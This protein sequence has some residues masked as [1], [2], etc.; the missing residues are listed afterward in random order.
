ML[1]S[2]LLIGG[3]ALA[4][5]P[6]RFLGGPD[7]VF[8]ASARAAGRSGY[9]IVAYRV[10][11]DGVVAD[12]TVVEAEPAGVFEAAALKAVR[13]WRFEPPRAAGGTRLRSRLEFRATDA[14]YEGIGA[15]RP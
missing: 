12:A 14:A 9:V 5:A 8:P 11:T 3:C 10:G 2:L 7:P 1:L 15:P 6:P 13:Q 4:P